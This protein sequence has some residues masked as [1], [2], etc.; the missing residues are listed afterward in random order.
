M[1]LKIAQELAYEENGLLKLG[2]YLF[3][4][5]KEINYKLFNKTEIKSKDRGYVWIEQIEKQN[6]IYKANITFKNGEYKIFYFNTKAYLCNDEGK[7]I[8]KIVV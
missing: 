6:K 2:W 1:I 3:G 5:I 4:D 7:T 8:E